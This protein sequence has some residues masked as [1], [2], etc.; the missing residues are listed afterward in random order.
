MTWDDALD[1]YWLEKRRG[2]SPNTVRGYGNV[3]RLFGGFVGHEREFTKITAVDV[4]KFL[5]AMADEREWSD[6]TALNAWIALSSMWSW[7]EMELGT[8]HVIRGKVT[9]PRWRRPQVEPY[10]EEEVAKLLFMCEHNASW[11]TRS[12]KVWVKSRRPTML[13]DRAMVLTLLDTGLRAQ[14][15]CDLK[16]AD[17]DR[18][19]GR[20]R[21]LHGK[22]DKQR[23]VF[24]GEVC[25][26]A[27]WRY[28]VERGQT[29]PDAA[30]FGGR[31]GQ[32]LERK[33]LGRLLRTM[34]K[35]A[36]IAN[37]TVH[38]FRHTFAIQFLRNGGNVLALQELLGHEKLD[39]VKIYARL[40]QV[41]LQAAQM[42]ASPAD[43]WKL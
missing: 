21:V 19:S 34:A 1:G 28:L 38:R 16:L 7:A 30:L 42:R 11:K 14:E 31:A 25:R 4:R 12:A 2:F 27:I 39:T 10:S 37:V 32:H 33:N 20:L 26:K 22:G 35:R 40:A 23:F 15:L 36:L 43:N 17:Y 13:R 3:F 24:A 5:N 29:M 8:P 18:Q 41:D 6:K 9:K